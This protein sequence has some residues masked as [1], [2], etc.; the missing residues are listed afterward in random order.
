MK[1]GAP[2]LIVMGA[3]LGGLDALRLILGGLPLDL[4]AAIA[5]VQHRREERETRMVELLSGATNIPVIEPDDGEVYT[6][7]NVYLAPAGYH[8][9]IDG[10]RMSLS[11]E[12]PVHY[13]RPSIDVL[14]ESAAVS[15]G[16]RL[17]SVLLT[18]SS[19]DGAA[20]SL[21]VHLA[22]GA[23]IV[24]EPSTAKS[25]VAPAAALALFAPSYV[26]NVEQIAALLTDWCRPSSE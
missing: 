12:A 16:A 14:F 3:S 5:I 26:A 17:A 6:K 18:G 9:L 2:P 25:A 4:R 10:A 8:L 15:C 7:S 21:A 20:G 13:A 22:G 11:T 23:T 24:Q 1:I 19:E